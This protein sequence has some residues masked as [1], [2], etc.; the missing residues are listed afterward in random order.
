MAYYAVG[1]IQGCFEPFQRL[2]DKLQF[3]PTTDRLWIAGDLV[4]RG[5][6]SLATL[7]FIRSLGDAAICVLGNHDFH[8]LA[9]HY[10]IRAR[11]GKD[12]TLDQVLDSPDVTELIDWLRHRPLLHHD[13]QLN[14]TMVHAGLHPR[15]SIDEAQVLARDIESMLQSSSPSSALEQLYGDTDTRWTS[16]RQSPDRLRYAV[17]CLTRMR[18]CTLDG[19]PDYQCA[20]PPGSQPSHLAPWFDVP[21]RPTAN[22]EIIFG[23]WAALGL[24]HQAGIHALDSGCVW[25]ESLSAASL[26]DFRITSVSCP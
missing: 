15:W 7:H 26:P 14:C 1:D 5:P 2:L 24:H 19:S 4:N 9:L 11:R 21:D 23:H 3:D 18:Y 6:E 25:G 17:N 12:R 20:D 10:G 22:T 16:A 13:A 8:L